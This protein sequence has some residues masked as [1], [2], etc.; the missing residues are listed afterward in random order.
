MAAPWP[1]TQLLS[2]PLY[3]GFYQRTLIIA[4]IIK[5]LSM[6]LAAA[7]LFGEIIGAAK[8]ATAGDWPARN[9]SRPDGTASFLERKFD[10][11][12]R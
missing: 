9:N 12:G 2:S 1:H 6:K 7:K 8:R 11:V 3:I 4:P 5:V 10:L